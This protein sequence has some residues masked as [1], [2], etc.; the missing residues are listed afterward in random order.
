MGAFCLV[1]KE[2]AGGLTPVAFNASTEVKASS[3]LFVILTQETRHIAF[4]LGV[5]L[6]MVSC[7][8]LSAKKW[9]YHVLIR[10]KY[11]WR[12]TSLLTL[13]ALLVLLAH[14][15]EIIL[16]IVPPR[17]SL[18][19]SPRFSFIRALPSFILRGLLRYLFYL[20]LLIAFDNLLAAVQTK[21]ELTPETLI[22]KREHFCALA[23]LLPAVVAGQNKAR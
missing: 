18:T 23:L 11:P 1:N 4:T 8:S 19:L 7:L 15:V 2:K 12:F 9:G 5:A 14:F 16:G 21:I 22:A 6:V 3:L 10:Q 20:L 13:F 17:I